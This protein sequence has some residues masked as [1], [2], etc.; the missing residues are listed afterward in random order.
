[1]AAQSSNGF[2]VLVNSALLPI[3]LIEKSPT[4]ELTSNPNDLSRSLTSD[5]H[6][7][8]PLSHLEDW[9]KLVD[10]LDVGE[11]ESR[12]L[13]VDGLDDYGHHWNLDRNR[14]SWSVTTTRISENAWSVLAVDI[15]GQY[16]YV[17]ML[18]DTLASRDRAYEVL[19][20]VAHELKQP[21]TAILGLAQV[22][23]EQSTDA[24]TAE[25]V[26]LIGS[27]ADGMVG[28]IDD[29]MTSG[30]VSSDRMRVDTEPLLVS[31]L[32]DGLKQVAATFLESEVTV[33][34]E[35]RRGVLVF[36]DQRRLNQVVRG[37]IQNAVKYGGP[38][39][40][41]VA[42]TD[43]DRF[44]V[45][46]RDD[47]SGV[48]PDEVESIFKPFSQGKAGRR[49]GTGIGLA[50]ARSIVADMGGLLEYRPGHPG[51]A[52]VITLHVQGTSTQYA[53][54][55][56]EQERNNLLADLIE[57]ERDASRLRLNR[58]TFRHSATQVIE[59]VVRPVMYEVGEQWA[60]GAV[61]VS[62]E[63]HA[64]SV[65]LSW[66]MDTMS[67][68]RPWR[69]QTVVCVSGPGGHHELGTA[70]VGVALAEAGYRVIYLGRGVPTDDL[71]ETISSSKATALMISV[72][73]PEQLDG[74]DEITE[75]LADKIE[76]GL[77]VG[78]GGHLF[79]MGVP[80]DNLPCEYFG[81]TARTAVEGLDRVLRDRGE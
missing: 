10:S 22:V 59:E 54:L 4:G 58:L 34:S 42:N 67:R 80:T 74:I 3:V 40:E 69:D 39:I 31:D 68:Y 61:S 11:S 55:D 63:H 81:N 25:L 76:D 27:S 37:L 2:A 57:Y 5:G 29:L 20:Q 44:V 75:R 7:W 48:P 64:S 24:E 79:E 18:E 15:T 14:T 49:M 56:P 73:L 78:V 72:T 62:Q 8:F 66:L 46:V 41:I 17:D 12:M 26:G 35:G 45:E 28:V 9:K 65:V 60:R 13:I 53:D 71:V 47:G 77:I 51:A 19:A 1:M 21:V 36:V 23:I 30:L 70:A 32:V 50:V 43:V 16:R 52:F 33:R 38:H 6:D